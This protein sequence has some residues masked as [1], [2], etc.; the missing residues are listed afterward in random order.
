MKNKMNTK[1]YQ[2]EYKKKDLLQNHLNTQ[3]PIPHQPNNKQRTRRQ[4]KQ[5]N[6]KSSSIQLKSN[7]Q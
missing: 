2:E 5:N 4:R 3:R 7:I 1:E 6:A